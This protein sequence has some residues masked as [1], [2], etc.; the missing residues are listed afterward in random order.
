MHDSAMRPRSPQEPVPLDV[1]PTGAAAPA[2]PRPL[3]SFIGRERE[4]AA[5]RGLLNRHDVRL[6]TLT[7]P[8][9][10]GKT[11][12]ATQVAA[13]LAASFPDGVTYVPLTDVREPSLVG[14][15][16]SRATRKARV[17]HLGTDA[18]L[19][20]L[21]GESCSLLVLDNFEHVIEAAPLVSRLLVSCPNL[22]VLVTSR[23]TL[24]LSSER[25]FVVPSMQLPSTNMSTTVTSLQQTEAVR[26]FTERAMARRPDFTLAD[27]NAAAVAALCRHVDG[28][29]LAIELAAAR[30]GT[31][32]PAALL[33]RLDP[34]L[35]L[36]IGGPTD[37]PSRHRTMRDTIAWSHDLLDEREQIAFRRLAVCVGGFTLDAAEAITGEP[38]II[39]DTLSALIANNLVAMT[40]SS[41]G[42][43]RYSMLETIREYGLER[44]AQ[45][46]G[47]DATSDEHL[48]SAA[49][50]EARDRHAAHFLAVAEWSDWAWF[51]VPSEG[52]LRLAQLE[53]ETAN[54][55][56]ALGWLQQHGDH[57]SVLRMAGCLGSLWVVLGHPHEGQQWL[58]RSLERGT[59]IPDA[60]RA[61]ALATLSWAVNTGGDPVQALALAEESVA[62]WRT[63]DAPL[64][65]AQALILCGV[66]AYR[67]AGRHHDA[68][69]WFKE[70][71][72][73]LTTLDK[74][75]WVP[76]FIHQLHCQLG[77]NALIHGNIELSEAHYRTAREDE[78]A[79]GFEPGE[80]YIYATALTQALGDLTRARGDPAGSL[81]WYQKCLRLGW[82]QHN[83]RIV[84]YSLGGVAGALATLGDHLT[85]ARL[86]GASE[87]LH[88]IHGFDFAM[89]VLDCQRA[90]GLPEPWLRAGDSF[91]DYQHLRDALRDQSRYPPIG[92][93]ESAATAWAEGR[94]VPLET[95]VA[96]AL[97]VRPNASPARSEPQFGLTPRE[98]E[99]L[100]YLVTGKSD[101]EIADALFISRRTAATHVR[102]IY[103]KLGVSSRAQAAAVAVRNHLA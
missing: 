79:R 40:E 11:R 24:E 64:H 32:P 55:R 42:A 51:M 48:A 87:E 61:R 2:L 68:T 58:E 35:P 36:L 71:I 33:A 101:G 53:A 52:E 20:A 72:A 15:S 98:L 73:I 50:I 94:L 102:H 49:E 39:I 3:T 29:P 96:E 14:A 85:A 76:N 63:L 93:P 31:L 18:D 6:L 103:D 91:G 95:T 26:L 4:V 82:R 88:R 41:D 74:P 89:E 77:K 70:S 81:G 84:S 12:L 27:H 25:V 45:R 10:I 56:A 30:V 21:F 62:V 83:V 59:G 8:G 23:K 66:P 75:D 38:D 69:P 60:I 99:V 67:V 92:N 46:Q 90:L 78:Q 54:I 19:V 28:L 57:T 1:I 47:E 86:F 16:I 97:A 100:Q 44:L 5:V 34:S 37:A 13:D 17:S 9:G 22:K 65:T 43:A 7:G 80:S